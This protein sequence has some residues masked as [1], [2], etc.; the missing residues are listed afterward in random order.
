MMYYISHYMLI[1]R[2]PSCK[3]R[4]ADKQLLYT[5]LLEKICNE[6]ISDDEKENKKMK[7]LNDLN[8]IRWCCRM[9]VITFVNLPDLII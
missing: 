4:L 3:T 7:L 5:T 6:D 2:C 1:P 9:R 8:I